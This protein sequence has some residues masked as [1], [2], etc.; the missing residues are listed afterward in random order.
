[1]RTLIY[2][3]MAM[4]IWTMVPTDAIASR[5]DR[6]DRQRTG[7]SERHDYDRYGKR[8]VAKKRHR[9]HHN[10][11]RYQRYRYWRPAPVR[12]IYVPEYRPINL[13]SGYIYTTSPGVSLYF[14]W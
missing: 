10:H 6:H 7:Y 11:A 13:S 3:F 14:S 4:F 5:G 8:Y 9:R 2:T 1:M 12:R